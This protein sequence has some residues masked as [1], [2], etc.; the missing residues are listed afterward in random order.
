[1]ALT[2]QQKHDAARDLGNRIFVAPNKPSHSGT[3]DLMAAV[4]S[5]DAAMDTV[6]NTIPAAWGTKTIKQALIDNLPEPFKSASTAEE[7]ALVLAL[8]AK[9]EVGLP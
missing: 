8:W 5:I 3:D 4:A 7:K 9:A 1:M 2:E 6:I